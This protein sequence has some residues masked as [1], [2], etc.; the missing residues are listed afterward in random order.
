MDLIPAV[1]LLDGLAVR[2]V[3]GDYQR[4]AAEG[5]DP[6]PLI[7]SWVA[8]GVRWLHLVDLEGARS[9]QPVHLELAA[10]LA[11]AAREAN[12]DARVELGG[13]MRT[14]EQVEAALEAGIDVAVLGTAAIEDPRLL[15]ECAAR[16][17]GRIAA[18]LD[19]RDER[20]A[21]DGWLRTADGGDATRLA[22][23]LAAAGAAHL[24]VTDVARDGT[25]RGANLTLLARMRDALPSTRLIAAGG[26]GTADDL[27]HLAAIGV[28]GAVVGLALLDGS[29]SIE[30]A[31]T[32]ASGSPAAIS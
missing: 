31:Q 16:W 17:P 28:D 14:A 20:P 15:G 22:T 11:A 18:S 25:K 24:I 3:Q 8:G 19:L 21:L 4:R 29:L 23:R 26:I 5:R 9:G 32:A 12:P 13:G 30:A 2:L 27:R 6:L 7:R 10:R 1:D